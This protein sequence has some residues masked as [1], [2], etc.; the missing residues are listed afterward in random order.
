MQ[1]DSKG[2]WFPEN[3]NLPPRRT[4][5][6]DLEAFNLRPFPSLEG[7]KTADFEN[8]PV[9]INEEEELRIERA[10][11][12]Q[13]RTLLEAV[14]V[15]LRT[16]AESDQDS[17]NILNLELAAQGYYKFVEQPE[18]HGKD[19]ATLI[20][21]R[22]KSFQNPETG[23]LGFLLTAY[24]NGQP[25]RQIQVETAE[26]DPYIELNKSF[27]NLPPLIEHNF[28]K[29]NGHV[30]ET[31]R[32]SSILT[33]KIL[34]LEK[35]EATLLPPQRD[36][37][38]QIHKDTGTGE[39]QYTEVKELPNGRFCIES[40]SPLPN[41]KSHKYYLYPKGT[42]LYN[43]S[44]VQNYPSPTLVIE[45][46]K[47][48]ANPEKADAFIES[49]KRSKTGITSKTWQI[50]NID[51]N[52]PL[53]I[54][55]MYTFPDQSEDSL[56]E[57]TSLEEI[58]GDWKVF[59]YRSRALGLDRPIEVHFSPTGNFVKIAGIQHELNAFSLNTETSRA[60][61]LYNND[62]AILFTLVNGLIK[63]AKLKTMH[64]PENNTN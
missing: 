56:D 23:N 48:R 46:S 15:T 57:E 59:H 7:I 19:I 29:V 9:A 6:D 28:Y 62:Q 60:M 43:S 2:I 51:F 45:L 33:D 21:N 18:I 34:Y 26:L 1:T 40:Y 8:P 25:V 53:S 47:L 3:I 50:R 35:D 42:I 49:Q 64:F 17:T 55:E 52:T 13:I 20:S 54:L 61:L 30:L 32:A 27:D 41:P 58:A 39:V 22:L 36:L 63:D 4:R 5:I 38:R 37:D 31:V 12:F 24:Y 44:D 10:A 14:T 16:E 11:I